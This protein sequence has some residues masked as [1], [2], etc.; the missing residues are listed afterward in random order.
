MST[1]SNHKK[2][3]K[4]AFRALEAFANVPIDTEGYVYLYISETP[5]DTS[6]LMRNGGRQ[7]SPLHTRDFLLAQEALDDDDPGSSSSDR[8]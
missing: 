7:R 4:A 6:Y 2:R 8:H 1:K 5:D 3:V